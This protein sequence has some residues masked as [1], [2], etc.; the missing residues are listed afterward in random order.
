MMIRRQLPVASP[1]TAANI[2]GATIA[3]IARRDAS[4]RVRNA[5]AAEFDAT[6]VLLTDSGTSALVLA[7]R[8]FAK[9]G[10]PVAMPAY[11]CVDLIAAARRADVRVRL[12]DVDPHTLSPDMDSLQRVLAEGVSAVVI[13]HLYGFPADMP[14]VMKMA[15][16]AGVPVIEDAAQHAGATVAEDPVGSFGDVTVLSFGR[17]KGTTAG[18]GGALL[19]RRTIDDRG[20]FPS[21]SLPSTPSAG[22]LAITAATWILGR[23]SSYGIPASIP[24]LHL[25]ETVYHDAAEPRRMSRAAVIL[26]DRTLPGMRRAASARQATALILLDAADQSR[27]IET[28]RAIETGESGYLRFPVMLRDDP[29]D[30][31]A[32]GIAR[33][34]P[35]PLS[36]E[37]Q[38]QPCLIASHEP[39]HGAH[40]LARRLVT[41]PTHHMVTTFDRAE[42]S[43]WL[44]KH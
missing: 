4:D 28:V 10:A 37:P 18:S 9:A 24:S 39:L 19:R 14:S 22:V 15:R 1:L 44:R 7:L 8:M 11:A 33:G 34:Y 20:N 21:S 5:L 38:I 43:S 40:E 30:N 36:L 16:A 32:L 23:P 31:V 25:G 27:N 2:V 42:L 13:A 29:R 41:L 12:F 26:L 17:G 6:Q 35:N 3:T